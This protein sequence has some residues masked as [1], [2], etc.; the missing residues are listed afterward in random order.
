MTL[1]D[2]AIPL[3]P[4]VSVPTAIQG[5]T[6]AIYNL[7][8][9]T[10]N[11]GVSVCTRVY[12]V[13]LGQVTLRVSNKKVWLGMNNKVLSLRPHLPKRRGKLQT[14]FPPPTRTFSGQDLRN[15]L[16]EGGRGGGR[17]RPLGVNPGYNS[18]AIN[19]NLFRFCCNVHL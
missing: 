19:V 2:D 3:F 13:A 9:G 15:H 14:G 4:H 7:S 12:E 18:G 8:S 16:W 1:Q 5:S 10:L 17:K 11:A 6:L